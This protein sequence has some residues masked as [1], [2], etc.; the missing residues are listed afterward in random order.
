MKTLSKNWLTEHVLDAEYK[1]YILLAYLSDV[2]REFDNKK[3]YPHLAEL[4][5]HH[6]QLIALKQSTE[7]LSAAFPTQLTQVDMENL[8]LNYSKLVN[9][10][11]MTELEDIINYSI[12]QFERYMQTGK[13][14]YDYIE[15]RLKVEPIGLLP[16][17][18]LEGYLFLKRP[19]RK[20]TCVYEYQVTLF[21]EAKEQYRSIR[22]EYVA[23][24]SQ[25]V[26]NTPE[27]IK[28][29]LIKR[30]PKLPNPAVY[31]IEP[32]M[33]IPLMETYLPIAKRA[34]IKRIGA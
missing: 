11:M 32:D 3:L 34:V 29:D 5:E 19:Q 33:E 24:F 8:E 16:L 28:T 23:S 31:Y 1:R 10:S 26:S 2:N 25:S 14:L 27:N 15:S 30:R 6:R 22:T 4:I 17:Y 18:A 9:D 20:E 12:P 7:S 13:Q 21:E